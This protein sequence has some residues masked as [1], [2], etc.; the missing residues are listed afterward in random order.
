MSK[1]SLDQAL[2]KLNERQ[3][4]A[5]LHGDGPLLIL[6]GAGSGKTSTMT[7]RIAHLIKARKVAPEAILGLS[8]TRKAAGELKERVVELS[9]VRQ[10]LTISTFHSLCVRMLRQFGHKLGYPKNFS[11][12][13]QDDSRDLL[14]QVLRSI[15]IDDRKFDPDRI[16]FEIGQAKNRFLEGRAAEDFFLTAGRMPNDYAIA[17]ASAYGKY[18]DR[19]LALGALDFD[20]LLFQTAKL[21]GKHEDA[22]SF[23]GKKYQHILVDEYQDTNPAQFQLLELMTEHHKNICVVGDDDQS[24]YGWRGADPAHILEFSKHFPGAKI[25]TLDQN[26]RSTNRILEAAN[27]VISKNSQRHKKSLWSGRGEGESLSQ[28]VLEDDRAETEFVSEEILRLA[29]GEGWQVGQPLAR[30]WQDFAILFRSNPQSRLF[31]EALRMR[32]IPYRLVGGMS[33][34]DRREIKDLLSYWRVLMNPKDEASLRRVINWPSR[35]IGKGAMEAIQTHAV[36]HGVS[37][38][39][40]L[41]EVHEDLARGRDGAHA[42]LQ[43]LQS[44]RM[45][46]ES[47][48]PTPGGLS[49]WGR[50]SLEKIGFKQALLDDEDDAAIAQKRWEMAEE[51]ANSL[52]Q[53]HPSDI[54]TTPGQ[55]LTAADILRDFLAKMT[56]RE[57]DEKDKDDDTPQDQVALLTLHAAKGL[58]FPIVYLVGMEDGLL[59][60]QKSIDEARDLSEERRLCY[61]GITRARDTLVLTRC[62]TRIRYGKAVPR[63]PSRFLLEIPQDLMIVDNKSAA[64][65][66][67]SPQQVEA[68]EAKVKDFLAQMRARLGAP[69]AR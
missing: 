5:V 9:G 7:V 20:D 64:P 35:G 26:Y 45:E 12:L 4:Q 56:L 48:P 1:T 40:A 2:K 22:R 52:G 37:F 33:F 61:V 14:R 69:P 29:R 67:N 59:P 21:L 63:N 46:L 41:K 24:I 11:I 32:G 31:E 60:H 34:L 42:F 58:E 44:L 6:A 15:K 51:L 25:V 62:R 66:P 68:H 39:E 53:M 18:Q 27:Q 57:L 49:Q 55:P 36:S 30:R 10:G 38:Y 3:R 19:L 13:D 16:A 43:L 47:T 8:F 65:D 54:E 23:Y 50:R 17:A 28:F